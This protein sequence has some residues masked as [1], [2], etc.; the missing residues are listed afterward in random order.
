MVKSYLIGLNI[1][2]VVLLSLLYN[3][4][5][6]KFEYSNIVGVN[7]GETKTVTLTI[8]KGNATG[9]ARLILGFSKGQ[10]IEPKILNAGGATPETESGNLIFRWDN[11]P[12]EPIITISFEVTGRM[13]GNQIIDG[14]FSYMD[15]T[16]KTIHLP[17]KIIH[18]YP[19]KTPYLECHR[20]IIKLSE[21]DY[22]VYLEINPGDLAGF[23]GIKENIPDGFAAKVIDAG[24]ATSKIEP[25][26][27]QIVFT[28]L[29]L[30]TDGEKISVKYQLKEITPKDPIYDIDGFFWAEYMIVDN[31]SVEYYI[32]TTNKHGFEKK[33]PE[34]TPAK[35]TDVTFKVQIM[36]AHKV[37]G[38][39]YF[40]QQ[41]KYETDFTVEQ[42]E[43]WQK[44]I[45]GSFPEYQFARDKREDLRKNTNLPKP[46][47]TAYNKN[48]RITVQEALILA[49]QKWLQ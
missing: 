42:H 13:H 40:R 9:A 24:D 5:K 21:Q 43:G 36:A 20:D 45:I 17:E 8:D 32:P 28:W 44:Y 48:E 38:K 15:G 29:D 2:G 30:P 33:S 7:I 23:G 39:A 11:L 31:K 46:F 22:E 41:H 27:N 47:V 12:A 16:R 25:T 4:D 1:V 37:V 26:K 18:V 19:E 49:N 34:I 10:G 35:N 14:E 3:Q 6:V